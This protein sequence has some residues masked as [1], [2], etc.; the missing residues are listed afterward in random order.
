MRLYREGLQT[1]VHGEFCDRLVLSLSNTAV[2]EVQ[3]SQ[4]NL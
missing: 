3:I 4:P 1:F 2:F